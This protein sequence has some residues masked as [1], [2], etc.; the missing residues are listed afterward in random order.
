VCCN[1][2][3]CCCFVQVLDG[4]GMEEADAWL[5]LRGI[6]AGLAHIHSQVGALH[7]GRVHGLLRRGRVHGL[8][9][10]IVVAGLTASALQD[11][12]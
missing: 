12:N 9:K 1:H 11:A 4:G 10:K 8:H 6:L 5:V 2:P 3:P 7:R